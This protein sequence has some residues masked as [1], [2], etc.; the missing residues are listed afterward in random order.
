MPGAKGE[1][2]TSWMKQ[3]LTQHFAQARHHVTNPDY[4]SEAKEFIRKEFDDMGLTVD[5]QHTFD[6]DVIG[7][8]TTAGSGDSWVVRGP[9]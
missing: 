6:T 4:K 8:S 9:D 5:R 3:T 2:S 1:V 7:V